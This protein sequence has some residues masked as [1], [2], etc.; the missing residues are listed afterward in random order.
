[1]N[2]RISEKGHWTVHKTETNNIG[3]AR[4]SSIR[5][6]SDD[7]NHDACITIVGDFSNFEERREYHDEIAYRLNAFL[8][9]RDVM[10][11]LSTQEAIQKISLLPDKCLISKDGITKLFMVE[12][13]LHILE[14]GETDTEIAQITVGFW[15]QIIW[16]GELH[17]HPFINI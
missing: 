5:I 17:P 15:T 4:G 8:D 3:N 11:E 10:G 13:T 7:F 14:I 2:K 16:S 1:M 6:D 9:T 12:G